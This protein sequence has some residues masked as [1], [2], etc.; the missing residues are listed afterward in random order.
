MENKKTNI[1]SRG[2]PQIYAWHNR[3][4]IWTIMN[5]MEEKLM[6]MEDTDPSNGDTTS[7]AV[8]II[9][10]IHFAFDASL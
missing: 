5:I 6:A 3:S 10:T 9:W 4:C 2:C 7:L 1:E 8:N